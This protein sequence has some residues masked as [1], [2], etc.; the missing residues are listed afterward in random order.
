MDRR[1]I[2]CVPISHWAPSADIPFS[3]LLAHPIPSHLIKLDGPQGSMKSKNLPRGHRRE[4]GHL[5][6][7]LPPYLKISRGV[8]SLMTSF[9]QSLPPRSIKT[10]VILSRGVS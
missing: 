8:S 7:S 5:T 9:A 3:S 6:Q 4:E 2:A 1:I 10:V